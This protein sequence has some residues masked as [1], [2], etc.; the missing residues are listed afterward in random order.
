METY[1]YAIAFACCTF[2]TIG[3]V[4]HRES[5]HQEHMR[6]FD[7]LDI[8]LD[9]LGLIQDA[10]RDVCERMPQHM[11]KHDIYASAVVRANI[12]LWEEVRELRAKPSMSDLIDREA[13]LYLYALL[14]VHPDYEYTAH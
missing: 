1:W 11:I 10:L 9:E 4:L 13:L 2:G 8:R 6:R 14:D 5:V 3:F 12:A 7:E